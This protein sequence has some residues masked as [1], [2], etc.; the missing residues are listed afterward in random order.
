VCAC[1]VPGRDLSFMKPIGGVVPYWGRSVCFAAP[2]SDLEN[3]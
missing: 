1:P 3:L 2:A